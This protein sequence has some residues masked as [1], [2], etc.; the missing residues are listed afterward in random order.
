MRWYHHAINPLVP[1]WIA[2]LRWRRF[3]SPKEL[4]LSRCAT[5]VLRQVIRGINTSNQTS[6]PAD[7]PIGARKAPDWLRSEGSPGDLIWSLQGMAA[8]FFIILYSP[9]CGCISLEVWR[10]Q[11]ILYLIPLYKIPLGTG[12]LIVTF[13]IL[14][15]RFS[16][17]GLAFNCSPSTESWR[18]LHEFKKHLLEVMRHAWSRRAQ[19]M[20]AFTVAKCWFMECAYTC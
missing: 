15:K 6:A 14:P 3:S 7:L 12:Y 10:N 13:L 17:D 2:R 8:W 11:Y 19:S 9:G 4:C 1:C 5:C 18:F 20:Y 16:S